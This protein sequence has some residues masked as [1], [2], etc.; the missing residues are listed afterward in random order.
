MEEHFDKLDGAY[1]V[2]KLRNRRG[3]CLCDKSWLHRCR[4]THSHCNAL[5]IPMSQKENNRTVHNG[6]MDLRTRHSCVDTCGIPCSQ[7]QYVCFL[8]LD[9]FPFCVT[10]GYCHIIFNPPVQSEKGI[11]RSSPG[12]RLP[13]QSPLYGHGAYCMRSVLNGLASIHDYECHQPDHP[14]QSRSAAR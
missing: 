5:Y 3:I 14:H 1:L 6:G 2:F 8:C 9:A 12:K 10:A 13:T 4:T 7:I 11:S